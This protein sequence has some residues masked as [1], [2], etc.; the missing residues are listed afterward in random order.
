METAPA[1]KSEPLVRV[2][3][4]RVLFFQFE[5]DPAV[6]K[7]NLPAAFDLELHDGKAVISVVAL[8]M[9]RFR[10]HAAGPFWARA[11]GALGEQRFLNLRTYVRHGGE[12]GAFFFW[13]WLSRRGTCHWPGVRWFDLRIRGHVLPPRARA[14][15]SAGRRGGDRTAFRLPRADRAGRSFGVLSVWFSRRVCPGAIRWIFLVSGRR[16][17]ISRGPSGVVTGAGHGQHR[18][19]SDRSQISLVRARPFYGRA[20]CAGF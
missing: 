5:V 20:V 11:F 4:R 14:E 9:R 16:P 8:T 2:E 7:M 6:A 17:R 10:R 15:P 19:Q 18:G 12:S 13:S 1:A 3:W